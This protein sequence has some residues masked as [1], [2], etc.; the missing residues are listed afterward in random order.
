MGAA[1]RMEPRDGLTAVRAVVDDA[2]PRRLGDRIAC[3]RGRV[4]EG[5]DKFSYASTATRPDW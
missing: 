5:C 4:H 2:R 1:A 3:V